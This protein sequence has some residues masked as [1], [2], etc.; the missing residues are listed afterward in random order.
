[1]EL[2]QSEVDECKDI[3][4][5]VNKEMDLASLS[6]ANLRRY[7]QADV[8]GLWCSSVDGMVAVARQVIDYVRE[9][10]FEELDEQKK[11]KVLAMLRSACNI[12]S[13]H[14]VLDSSQQSLLEKLELE[15]G[16]RSNERLV[17]L[18]AETQTKEQDPSIQASSMPSISWPQNGCITLE[19]IRVLISTFKWASW[20]DPKDFRNLMPVAVVIKL[21]EAAYKIMEDEENCVKI[22]VE[23]EE[24]SEVVVVG[25]IH[26][27]FHDLISLFEENAGFPSYDR[28]FVFS[29]NYIGRGSWCLE[30]LL[31]LLAFKVMLPDRVYLLRGNHESKDWTLKYGFLAEYGYLEEL[32]FVNRFLENVP[33]Y[34]ILTDVLWSNPSSD[35][36]IKE[37]TDGVCGGIFW[38]P[39]YT[40]TFLRENHLKLI[41]RSHEGPDARDGQDDSRNMLNGYCKDHDVASGKLFTLFSAP[42]YPQFARYDNVGAYAVLKPPKFDSPSFLPLKAS[43]RPERIEDILRAPFCSNQYK[44]QM[45]MLKNTKQMTADIY[46]RT[47]YSELKMLSPV[48]LKIWEGVAVARGGSRYIC[49]KNMGFWLHLDL[50][51]WWLLFDAFIDST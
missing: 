15:V 6:N 32:A 40:E 2:V 11:R 34:G 7:S 35:S 31:V 33:E 20:K 37:N 41:I 10:T 29:G 9:M 5:I 36:R 22:Y 17:G 12:I 21:I 46:P 4:G 43:K 47:F 49:R 27:Q 28:Y 44:L 42:S 14:C 26:G 30:V 51:Q 25:D 1:M 13:K 48:L 38:G 18:E 16:S 23:D 19:W 3:M 39:N 8:D 50:L 45:H 24:D